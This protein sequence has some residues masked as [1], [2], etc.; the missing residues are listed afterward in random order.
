M[1]FPFS[2][3]GSGTL[4]VVLLMVASVAA[5]VLLTYRPSQNGSGTLS[6]APVEGED[7][8]QGSLTAPAV[9]VE[10]SD[11]QCPACAQF[12]PL[13]KQAQDEFG[14]K[15]TLVYRHFPLRTI[16][17][18][19]NLA[20]QA[21]EAAGAQGKFWEMHRIIF[22]Q[23]QAWANAQNAR[24]LMI[25]YARQLGLNA[26]QFV[27]DMD[28]DATKARIDRDLASGVASGVTGTPSFFLNGKK[29]TPSS[30]EGFL[31]SIRAVI[32]QQ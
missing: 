9:L 19:A 24:D 6:S 21:A 22:D 13:I 26:Q 30:S 29:L 28:A 10:Y 15:L 12:E 7:R 14:D 11:F 32:E 17:A 20:A 31:N 16:H 25:G 1:Q 2:Q 18:N 27:R 3:R 4:W 5:L 23:Q 8:I